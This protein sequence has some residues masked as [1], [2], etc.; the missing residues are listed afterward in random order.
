MLCY[1]FDC[2][3]TG[4]AIGFARAIGAVIFSVVIGLT[5][6]F[7]FYLRKERRDKWRVKVWYWQK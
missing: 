4:L 3:D 5:M 6:H 2:S 1:H 7:I